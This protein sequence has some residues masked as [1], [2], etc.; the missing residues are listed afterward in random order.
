MKKGYAFA[1]LFLFWR[2]NVNAM[3]DIVG[4]IHGHYTLLVKLLKKLGYTKDG[5]VFRHPERKIIFTGDFINRGPKIRATVQ[6]IRKMVE[7]GH[8]Y[9]ILGNHE[10]NAILYA[11]IDKSSGKS[12][13]K[14]LPRYKL[15]LMKT[16]EEYQNYPE[17]FKDTIK[18]FRSL[19]VFLDFG[20][21]RVVHGG[22]NEKNISTVQ[23]YKNGE[24]KLKKSF[25]KAYLNNKELNNAL[26][27][28]VKGLE[29]QLPKD[30]LLKDS[31]GIVR[32]TFRI[33]WWEQ[34]N[35]KTFS[36]VA[37]GN[38]FELPAYTIPKEVLP[39][40]TPYPND[41]P[42]VFLGHYCLNKKAMI[43]QENICCIDTCVVKSQRLTCY[44]W[45]GEQ[46]LTEDHIVQASLA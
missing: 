17:E 18:W 12:L 24:P 3:Y 4:D 31:N 11:T 23:E 29:L 7:G 42:P 2:F 39:E 40:V 6:L 21:L 13:Q 34:P 35:G 32:R 27:G 46:K 33:K 14:H 16:L 22:W 41:A 26:N 8:A 45:Y 43:F 25:L 10:L 19:P 28:L 30:L 44:R 36:E 9:T 37:F 1:A 20:N 38:R 15:P 5:D